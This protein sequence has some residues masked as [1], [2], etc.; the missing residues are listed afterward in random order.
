MHDTI[1]AR[2]LVQQETP[3]TI[4]DGTYAYP[5][6]NR[7]GELCVVDFYTQMAME[8]RGFEVRA[9][10]LSATETG[11]A[12]IATTAAEMCVDAVAGLTLIPVFFNVA[13]V[14]GAGT[15]QF[16]NLKVIST[17][18]SAGTVRTPLPLWTDSTVAALSTG[19]MDD[20]GGVT[21]TADSATTTNCLFMWG[22]AEA[23][24][25]YQLSRQWKPLLPAICAGAACIYA[26]IGAT[27]SGPE[28]HATLQYIELPTATI[29]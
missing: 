16:F 11:A 14:T 2:S 17:V 27:T 8:K 4:G 18:S 10:A 15:V 7:R 24:G 3:R 26:Q 13:V 22:G 29:E 9:G 23:L 19:R 25:A 6:L 28:Y 12:S 1:Q 20:T 21:V 5:K